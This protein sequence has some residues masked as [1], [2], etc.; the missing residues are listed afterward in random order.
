[1]A[2]HTLH[3]LS[4][5]SLHLLQI[6]GIVIVFSAVLV[7]LCRKVVP[8]LKRSHHGQEK[9]DTSS[10]EDTQ[11][12]RKGLSRGCEEITGSC[13]NAVSAIAGSSAGR[14]GVLVTALTT[15]LLIR[16]AVVSDCV[17][18]YLFVYPPLSTLHQVSSRDLM[19]KSVF[20]CS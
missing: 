8:K 7:P 11:P 6:F 12:A 15:T 20:I 4:R 10:I 9:S 5:A 14:V 1:M 18:P 17:P 19:T 2:T 16:T 3:S 13:A